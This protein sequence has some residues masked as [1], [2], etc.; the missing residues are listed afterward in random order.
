MAEE[1]FT[2]DKEETKIVALARMARQRHTTPA[3]DVEAEWVALAPRLET[4]RK[5]YTI[6]HIIG[7]ATLGAAAMFAGMMFLKGSHSL[8]PA[9][10]DA[11]VAMTHQPGPQHV[12]LT[13]NGIR[14]NIENTDSISFYKPN[15]GTEGSSS[16]MPQQNL[17]ADAESMQSLSTPR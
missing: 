17:S 4:W 1:N 16:A 13:Q 9:P 7:A 6:W 12:V 2:L 10:E 8:A 11:Y 5:T 14:E 3:P 15:N